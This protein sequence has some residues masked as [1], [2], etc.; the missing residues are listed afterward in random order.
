MP[1][2]ICRLGLNF[3]GDDTLAWQVFEVNPALIRFSTSGVLK[4]R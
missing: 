1:L 3:H 4:V 2:F